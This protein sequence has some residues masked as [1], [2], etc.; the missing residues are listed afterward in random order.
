MYSRYMIARRLAIAMRLNL[1][2]P[3]PS[4]KQFYRKSRIAEFDHLSLSTLQYKTSTH[5]KSHIYC[6][7]F[8]TDAA[9]NQLCCFRIYSS[10]HRWCFSVM[11]ALFQMEPFL[12]WLDLELRSNYFQRY[13]DAIVPAVGSFKFSFLQA[14]CCL[15]R[16]IHLDPQCICSKYGFYS[17]CLIS[18]IT[19]EDFE[20]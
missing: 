7:F 10:W 15:D 3:R 11:I 12:C 2:L 18:T 1:I 8:I 16:S 13:N 9:S 5:I 14:Y 20:A 6:E 4:H 17:L 19:L